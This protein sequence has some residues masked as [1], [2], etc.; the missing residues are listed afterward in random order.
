MNNLEPK[1]IAVKSK[2][3]NGA[4]IDTGGG[5]FYAFITNQ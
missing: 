5:I 2:D 4:D 1:T 3:E